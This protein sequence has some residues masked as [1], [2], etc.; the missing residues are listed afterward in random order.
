MTASTVPGHAGLEGTGLRFAWTCCLFFAL[1]L[2]LSPILRT[3]THEI[4][5]DTIWAF[6]TMCFLCNLLLH[7]YSASATANL[8][9]FPDS[10]S[11]NAAI[12]ASVLLASR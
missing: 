9:K 1:L 8:V 11:I 7:E 3:L 5:S 10:I 2:G 4:S 6:T 12:F